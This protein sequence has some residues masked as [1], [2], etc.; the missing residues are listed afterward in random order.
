MSKITPWGIVLCCA[1]SCL[2]VLGCPDPVVEDDDTGDDDTGDDDDTTGVPDDDDTTDDDD[3]ADDD[4]TTAVDA[5]GDGYDIHDDCNDNDD[6]IHPDAVEVLDTVDQNCDGWADEGLIA[7]G[8]LV[9]TEIFNNAD[10]ADDDREWFEIVNVADHDINLRNW[11]VYDLDNDDHVISPDDDLIVFAGGT[12]VM[13]WS[14]DTGLNGDVAV[15]YEY[16]T[17]V[18]LGNGEDELLLAIDVVIDEVIWD[19]GAA[20]PSPDGASMTLDPELIDALA[21]DDG[22]NWCE[23]TTDWGTGS[24]GTPGTDNDPCTM[25]DD[26]DGDGHDETVDCD[27]NDPDSYPGAPELCDGVD[28]DCDGAPAADETTDDDGDGYMACEDCDDADDAVNPGATE[29][30]DNGID[31]DCDGVADEGE[32]VAGAVVITEVMQ[33]PDAVTDGEGEYFEVYNASGG[34]LDLVGCSIYDLGTNTHTIATSLVIAA[35]G[36]AVLGTNADPTVNGGVTVDYEYG[37]DHSL[38]NGDDELYL[39]CGGVIDA[40]EWDGGPVWPDPTG[41]AM[42]LDPAT[43]DAVANDDGL[44]WCD[45]TTPYGSGDLGTPG[46]A[47]DPC[48]APVDADGD[49]YDDTVDCDDNDPAVNPGAIEDPTNGID[50]D[51]DGQVDE[52]APVDA[53]GDGYDDTIDC[54][55]NDPAVN[56][57]AAEDPTNGIDDDC[58]GLVDEGGPTVAAGDVIFTEVMQNPD[59]VGDGDGEYFEVFNTTGADIDLMG[60][61]IYDLGSNAHT[62]ALSV[63]VPAG[64][65]AVFGTNADPTANGGVTVDYEYGGAIS[66]GNGDDELVL[67]CGGVIDAIEWDGGTTWPDPTGAAMNLDPSFFDAAG[68]D[69]GTHWC[70]ASTPYGS[71]DLGTPGAANDACVLPTDA[72]GDGFDETVDCDDNDA[73]VNPGAIEDP[74][75][76]IDDDCDGMVD[77]VTPVLVAGDVIFTEVMQDPA[78]VGDSDGEYF[79]VYNTTGADIDLMGCEIYDLGSN[80]HTIA[81]SVTVTAGGRAVFGTNADAAANGGVTVDYE[82]GGDIA[83]G[84]GDDELYLDCGGVIDAIEWDGGTD[85][86][87]PTG[88]AMN[89]DPTHLDATDNDDGTNWCEASVPYGAGDLGSPGWPNDPC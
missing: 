68:N 20:F 36:Y 6:T 35:G 19:D 2:L 47:N 49:G 57:G 52:T 80:A 55:D 54:D 82:Y 39:D 48:L 10:G 23:A 66:L 75:N 27:D 60:C 63:T 22:A 65:Y 56:P 45:A 79:E 76:G 53:D 41:A 73:A 78:A 24:L 87:D 71:G 26:A 58:D 7:P 67:D 42:N 17:A 59:A 88:A 8:E 74:T 46:A 29:I 43:L 83:L 4:D 15:D 51:C 34:V 84:N 9:I 50:D 30:A 44:N 16:G 11:S 61:E 69:L 85:W 32:L 77:E 21:N 86:P 31:D 38:G 14:A 28:N 18:N 33:N 5:D 12:L 81:L 3:T 64:G 89:L 70:E 1:V 40:V 13:G 72:D 25:P 62:I 37:G